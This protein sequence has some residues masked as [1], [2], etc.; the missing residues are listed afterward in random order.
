MASRASRTSLMTFPFRPSLASLPL[1]CLALL[2]SAA[3]SSTSAAPPSPPAFPTAEGFGAGATGGR[4]GEIYHVANLN[5]SGPGS[6][7]DAVSRGPRIVI[8]DVAGYIDLRSIVPVASDITILGQSAP[9]DGV[10][11]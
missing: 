10:A 4:A 5:D 11:T 1:L 6:F 8:F 2:T 3:P 7:R 9:G